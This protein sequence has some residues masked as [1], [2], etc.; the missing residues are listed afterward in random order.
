M[1]KQTMRM[2]KLGETA[3]FASERR[4][5]TMTFG[6]GG[7]LWSQVGALNQSDA[8]DIVGRAIEAGINFIDTADVYGEGDSEQITGQALRN[9]KIPREDIVIATKGSSATGPGPN[10]GG[11]SRL[12][13]MDA[14]K[15]SLKRLQL[16]HV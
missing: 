5:D 2:N 16:E 13:I 6:V 14:L 11:S 3:L 9:L 8:D 10:A 1:S 7:D 15:A 4:P 12:H